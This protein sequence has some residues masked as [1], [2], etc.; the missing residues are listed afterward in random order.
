MKF[1]HFT[2]FLVIIIFCSININSEIE[3]KRQR[4]SQ[5]KFCKLDV[6]LECLF[7]PLAYF[8]SQAN[9]SGIANSD[10]EMEQFCL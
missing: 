2:V 6:F 9:G 5:I 8:T 4:G 7:E 3:A 10:E 1:L